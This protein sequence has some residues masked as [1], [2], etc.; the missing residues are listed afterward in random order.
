MRLISTARS[1]AGIEL[2]Q[3]ADKMETRGDQVRAGR[4]KEFVALFEALTA[5]KGTGFTD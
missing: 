1:A 5:V 4:V 3:R 2:P